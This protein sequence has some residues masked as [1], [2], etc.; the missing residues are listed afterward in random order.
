[1]IVVRCGNRLA[2]L[3]V[4]RRGCKDV[5]LH[6]ALR[7][8]AGS[9]AEVQVGTEYVVPLGP[10]WLGIGRQGQTA[11][12]EMAKGAATRRGGQR[13][14]CTIGSV[15]SILPLAVAKFLVVHAKAMGGP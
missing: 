9:T 2:G 4:D 6:H 14:R 7:D 10:P 15:G 8:R 5:V 3:S 11:A 12:G 1:M 13:S